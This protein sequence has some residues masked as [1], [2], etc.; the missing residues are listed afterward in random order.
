M[1]NDK[2]FRYQALALASTIAVSL[3]VPLLVGIF[4]GRWMDVQIGTD[5]LFMIIGLLVGLVLGVYGILRLLKE[6]I[7]GDE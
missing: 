4:L 6:K 1:Q 2:R 3:A 7:Q 5:P